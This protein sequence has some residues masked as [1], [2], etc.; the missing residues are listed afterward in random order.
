MAMS[1]FENESLFTK[2][3][4]RELIR[5]YDRVFQMKTE[6]TS[7]LESI[8]VEI[9]DEY[10][11]E[12]SQKESEKG[13]FDLEYFQ[14]CINR[15]EDYP[16]VWNE[17]IERI[18]ELL[19]RV[20]VLSKEEPMESCGTENVKEEIDNITDEIFERAKK[21]TSTSKVEKIDFTDECQRIVKAELSVCK[22]LLEILRELK[23]KRT[24]VGKGALLGGFCSE[25]DNVPFDLRKTGIALFEKPI[26][27]TASKLGIP[28]ATAQRIAFV[29]EFFHA[30]HAYHYA[31]IHGK[32]VPNKTHMERVVSESLA[33]Y[34]E[35]LYSLTGIADSKDWCGDPKWAENK[36][37]E[38]KEYNAK[39]NPWSGALVL[40]SKRTG[41]DHTWA[42]K[43]FHD[44]I[45][46][47]DK[48]LEQLGKNLVDVYQT[49]RQVYRE[50]TTENKEGASCISPR[51]DEQT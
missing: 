11:E 4:K 42:A 10:I 19:N 23:G 31:L 45:E 38:W 28:A 18:I 1:Q 30:Y 40:E 48:G 41:E 25:R 50:D 21:Y 39:W 44:A 17:Q 26:D 5:L 6:D 3:E 14:Y 15:L 34:V 49:V 2:Q 8:P 37:R 9:C 47:E 24:E 22:I 36:I 46:M 51:E 43:L 20:M 29:H 32:K 12:R 16:W 13:H 27:V 7:V 35:Y 33:A